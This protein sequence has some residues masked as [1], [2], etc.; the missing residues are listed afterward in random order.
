MYTYIYNET[1]IYIYIYIYIHLLSMSNYDSS[2]II[3]GLRRAL[4]ARGRRGAARD[5]IYA[6]CPDD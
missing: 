1:N 3:K 4:A 6:T 5:R 2:N